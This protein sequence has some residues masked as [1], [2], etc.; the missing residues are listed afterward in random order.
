[1]SE[2]KN[3]LVNDITEARKAMN[4]KK[5][6]TLSFIKAEI[7]EKERLKF[8]TKSRSELTYDEIK[9]HHALLELH[10]EAAIIN[11]IIK[12]YEEEIRQFKQLKHLPNDRF[13]K[14]VDSRTEKINWVKSYLTDLRK[15]P[16]DLDIALLD[17]CIDYNFSHK[18][19]ISAAMSQISKILY[20][21]D[22]RV[23]YQKLV[24]LL[25]D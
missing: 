3:R 22:K 7:L 8:Y 1:M 2:I 12:N 15:S 9:S 14:E 20:F 17:L 24:E 10:E 6:E 19:H 25:K 16:E 4:F 13:R 21:E 23:L 11:N 18:D 5:T